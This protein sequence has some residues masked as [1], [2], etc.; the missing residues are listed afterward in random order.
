MGAKTRRREEKSRNLEKLEVLIRAIRRSS[1]RDPGFLLS[2]QRYQVF[3]SRL[4]VFA[5]II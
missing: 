3:S 2:K 1:L 4:R 5:P